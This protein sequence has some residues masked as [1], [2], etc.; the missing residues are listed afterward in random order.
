[1][2]N[3]KKLQYYILGIHLIFLS[4]SLVA[5][6]AIYLWDLGMKI[7]IESQVNEKVNPTKEVLVGDGEKKFA[8]LAK[9][10]VRPKYVNIDLKNNSKKASVISQKDFST[11][12]YIEKYYLG[13]KY[14]ASGRFPEAIKLFELVDFSQLSANQKIQLIQLHADALFNLGN[15]VR[16]VNILTENKEY[17]LNDELLFLLGM[18]S[19]E[20]GNKKIALN[21]FNEIIEKHPNSDYQNIAKLQLRV[22]KR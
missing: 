4:S 17:D 1:M 11:L 21:A 20:L 7:N 13:K 14:F 2:I 12:N 22:L 19:T 16:I 18:S 5:E 8:V 3:F 10:H 15:Y 9:R 6:D